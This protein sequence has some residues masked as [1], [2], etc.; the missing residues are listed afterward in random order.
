MALSQASKITGEIKKEWKPHFSTIV[1]QIHHKPTHGR[2]SILII[3]D[4]E[5]LTGRPFAKA[6]FPPGAPVAVGARAHFHHP[7]PI[8]GSKIE[9]KMMCFCWHSSS[10]SVAGGF[11]HGPFKKCCWKDAFP[12]I[13]PRIIISIT[14]L[15]AGEGKKT[16][17]RLA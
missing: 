17:T 12:N 9:A 14:C 13:G 16:Q 8:E 5:W 3:L 1:Q 11:K 4:L 2:V 7:S 10:M 15:A 6:L